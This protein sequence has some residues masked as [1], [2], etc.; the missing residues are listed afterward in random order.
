MFLGALLLMARRPLL[1][2]APPQP[3]VG[4]YPSYRAYLEQLAWK[5]DVTYG[6]IVMAERYGD[7]P[8]VLRRERRR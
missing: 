6:E 3:W 8:R 2:P 4:I 7:V 5:G 1:P